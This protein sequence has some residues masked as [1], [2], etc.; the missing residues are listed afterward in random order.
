M[1][2]TFSANGS[3]AALA[4]N[5]GS[6]YIQPQGDFGGGSLAVELDLGSGYKT[7]YHFTPNR[8]GSQIFDF[9]AGNVRLTL[10]GSTSPNL[11]TQLRP[12]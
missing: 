2:H 11:T 5:G 3:S 8:S 6:L 1:N 12:V 7:E 10:S 4:H 9:P